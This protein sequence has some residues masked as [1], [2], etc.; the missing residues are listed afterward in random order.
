MKCEICND[1][2]WV[3]E[4]H[5]T[6]EWE[7]GHR[8]CGA[9]MPCVCNDAKPPWCFVS[10][11]YKTIKIDDISLWGISPIADHRLEYLADI[12]NGEYSLEDARQDV[13]SLRDGS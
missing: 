13:L 9:G 3:C 6:E 8:D 10:K 4:N 7:D 1:S 12:L 11:E 2:G 5:Q